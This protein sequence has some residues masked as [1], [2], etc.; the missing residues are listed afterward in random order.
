MNNQEKYDQAKKRV[1]A[2]Y[3]FYIHLSFYS[4]VNLL[5]IVINLSNLSEGVWFIYPLMGWGIGLFIHGLSAFV[6]AGRKSLITE[7]MIEKEMNKESVRKY[8]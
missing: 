7:K 3:G 6:F 8:E 4:A 5:L 2:K 1:M